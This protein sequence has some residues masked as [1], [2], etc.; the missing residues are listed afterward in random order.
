MLPSPYLNRI[1]T[2]KDTDFGAQWLACKDLH[3]GRSRQKCYHFRP[4]EEGRSRWLNVLRKTLSFS[5]PS[6]FIP[7]LS[8]LVVGVQSKGRFDL[9]CCFLPGC[10]FL[11]TL[12]RST[13]QIRDAVSPGESE[14]GAEF[15]ER[16]SCPATAEPRGPVSSSRRTA[17]SR[18]IRR[19]H[20]MFQRGCSKDLLHTDGS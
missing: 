8:G 7:A 1:G 14:G 17:E 5:I 3:I 6:R 19:F 4:S 11:I 13:N 12:L 9:C 15:C 10:R 2:R 16:G 20:A 18:V